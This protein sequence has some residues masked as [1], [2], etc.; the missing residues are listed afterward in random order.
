MPV[1]QSSSGIESPEAA[2]TRVNCKAVSEDGDL[3]TMTVVGEDLC[4]GRVAVIEPGF[5]RVDS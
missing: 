5:E 2:T 1:G 4:T 3:L